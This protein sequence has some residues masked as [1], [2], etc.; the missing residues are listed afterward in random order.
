[1]VSKCDYC[2]TVRKGNAEKPV[3]RKI[4]TLF[5]V[6]IPD[7]PS[8]DDLRKIGAQRGIELDRMRDIYYSALQWS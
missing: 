4:N 6:E 2:G 7:M 3:R 1:M 8:D 5:G